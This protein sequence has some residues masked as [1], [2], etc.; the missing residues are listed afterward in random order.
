MS[1]FDE[2]KDS[3]AS[4]DLSEFLLFCKHFEIPLSSKAQLTVYRKICDQAPATRFLKQHFK[5]ALSL[6]FRE[7]DNQKLSSLQFILRQRKRRQASPENSKPRVAADGD[8]FETIQTQIR[9]LQSKQEFQ[10]VEAAI[11]WLGID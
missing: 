11:S 2:I 4:L 9:Q 7:L 8:D 1:T 3:R 6:L 10:Y 5:M